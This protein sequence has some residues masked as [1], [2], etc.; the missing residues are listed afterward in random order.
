MNV[1]VQLEPSVETAPAVQYRWD[2]DTDVL[3]ARLDGVTAYRLTR[4]NGTIQTL[5]STVGASATGFIDINV[6]NGLW[7]Y[8]AAA[9]NSDGAA[10]PASNVVAATVAAVC[11]QQTESASTTSRCAPVRAESSPSS[12]C[13]L[14]AIARSSCSIATFTTGILLSLIQGS[15]RRSVSG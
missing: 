8:T 4:S 10:G 6:P 3:T 2:A 15:P 7:L 1:A 12:S 11:P 9:V 13:S 5:V 14:A